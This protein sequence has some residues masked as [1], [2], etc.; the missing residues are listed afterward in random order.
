MGKRGGR[1]LAS[2]RH[3][4]AAI[5]DS[6]NDVCVA[7]WV[8]HDGHV[9]VV[10]GRGTH[11]GWTADV[12]LV[13]NRFA[14]SARGNGLHKRVKVHHNKFERLNAKLLQLRLVVLQAHVGKQPTVNLWVQRFYAAIKRLRETGDLRNL[15]NWDA[16]VGDGLRG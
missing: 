3:G 8:Y 15:G 16:G 9:G 13:D 12:D 1:Q 6:S 7:R 2:L 5:L 14:L 11:H 10:F 4:G